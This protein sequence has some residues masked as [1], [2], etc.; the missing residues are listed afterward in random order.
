MMAVVRAKVQTVL[1]RTAV[2]NKRP[3]RGSFDSHERYGIVHGPQA[4]SA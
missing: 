2:M 1:L 3:I 4:A